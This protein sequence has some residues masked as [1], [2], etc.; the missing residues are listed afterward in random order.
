MSRH[1]Y[2]VRGQSRAVDEELFGDWAVRFLYS[3]ARENA[4][5]LF[6]SLTGARMSRMLS[7]LNFDLPLTAH[8]TGNRRFLK[9]CGVDLEECL[10]DPSSFRTSRQIF[11]RRIRYWE[12]RPMPED[13]AAIVSPSDSKMVAGSF[14]H[15]STLF[16]KNKFFE[17]EELLGNGRSQWLDRFEKGDFAIFRL[18]PEMYHYNHSPVEGEV[19]DFY[20]VTG[21][22]HSC[23]PNAVVEL[24]T[25]YSKNKRVVTIIQTD[26]PGGSGVGLVAMIEVVALMIGEVVQCCSQE[27]YESPSPVT[28]GLT[29]RRGAP[30]SLYRPGSSTN[31]LLFE[32]NR[33]RFEEDILANMRRN[34]VE[35]RFTIAF[36]QPLVET[37]V[38]VRS[39]I[40]QGIS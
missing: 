38:R 7:M 39:L 40:A 12:T 30:K 6:R 13:P 17:F 3:R 27:R 5:F 31:I 8:L 19:V 4:P 16:L 24:V 22:Y 2:V 33:V 21:H 1:Q 10:D 28:P 26:V 35:S 14:R 15:G 25:P 34:D 37:D 9:S 36:G 32:P 23:N 18:T 29:L 11:E 20:E